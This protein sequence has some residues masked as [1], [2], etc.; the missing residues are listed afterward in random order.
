[1]ITDLIKNH[2]YSPYAVAQK[3]NNARWPSDA[4]VCEKMI[5]NYISSDVFKDLTVK[6]LLNKG[7]KHKGKQPKKRFSR[8]ACATRSISNRP[9]HISNR[10]Q[11][12]HWEMDT[13]KGCASSAFQCVLTIT[14]R[15]TR[16]EIIRKMPKVHLL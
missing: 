11:F 7:I 14:E 15:K 16:T 13:V 5:Y 10:S 6:D 9:E 4:R 1:M 3:F 8:A 2:N 12:G